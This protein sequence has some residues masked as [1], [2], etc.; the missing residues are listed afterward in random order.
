MATGVR[1][2][3]D[4]GEH[5]RQLGDALVAI[6]DGRARDRALP[7]PPYPGPLPFHGLLHH[8]LRPGE[9]R[10]LREVRDAE[11][12]VPS[13]E[14]LQLHLLPATVAAAAVAW[15]QESSSER[16]GPRGRTRGWNR[17]SAS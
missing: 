2:V 3:T 10:D 12:L 17:G 8:D 6:D 5:A 7:P 13:A 11:D 9:R 15:L 4:A 14:R 16:A 1:R